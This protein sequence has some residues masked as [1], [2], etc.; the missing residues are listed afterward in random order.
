M[1]LYE[2]NEVSQRDPVKDLELHRKACDE[3]RQVM[4][5]IKQ[6]KDEGHVGTEDGNELRIHGTLQFVTL[7]KLNRIAHF[8]SKK[9]RETTAEVINIFVN[10]MIN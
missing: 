10:V 7:R 8:R 3:L 6:L 2:E 4:T 9:V 5:Q 1:F